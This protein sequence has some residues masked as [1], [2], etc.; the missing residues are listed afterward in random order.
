[1]LVADLP[2]A[3]AILSSMSTENPLKAYFG[4]ASSPLSQLK[5]NR[6]RMGS[7]S[8]YRPSICHGSHPFVAIQAS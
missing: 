7:S 5:V 8:S 4:L 1:V 6:A 3:L 2:I